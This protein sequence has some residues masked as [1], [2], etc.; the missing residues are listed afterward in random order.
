MIRS[1]Q[2]AM[3]SKLAVLLVIGWTLAFVR[4]TEAQQ[5]KKVPRIGFLATP[6][7]PFSPPALV[8]FGKVFTISATL[9]EKTLLLNT[10]MQMESSIDSPPTLPS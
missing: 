5:P 10:G 4:L 6:S 8:H 7:T 2:A 3:V 1:K 9:K